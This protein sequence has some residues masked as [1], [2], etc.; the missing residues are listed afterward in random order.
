MSQDNPL[1]VL[2]AKEYHSSQTTASTAITPT[3]SV[4]P[5]SLIA[6][7]LGA[8]PSMGTYRTANFPHFLVD[9]A[10]VF[11]KEFGYTNDQ[12]RHPFCIIISESVVDYHL[13]SEDRL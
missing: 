1:R 13:R 4:Y 9:N 11:E 10:Q 3:D 12:I 7:G 5:T 8:V 2:S 6:N